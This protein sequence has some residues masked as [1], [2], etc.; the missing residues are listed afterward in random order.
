ME[1]NLEYHSKLPTNQ[2]GFRRG[3]GTKNQILACTEAYKS[4]DLNGLPQGLVLSPLLFNVYIKQL[5]RNIRIH[6]K[7]TIL[8]VNLFIKMRNFVVKVNERDIEYLKLG[9]Y[10]NKSE[11]KL[12][13]VILNILMGDYSEINCICQMKLIYYLELPDPQYFPWVQMIFW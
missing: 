9:G 1:W 7:T 10:E 3:L 12:F 5:Q 2:Y 4:V 13:L 11:I 8:K 6:S